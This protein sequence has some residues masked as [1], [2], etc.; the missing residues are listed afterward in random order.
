VFLRFGGVLHRGGVGVGCLLSEAV[1]LLLL[2]LEEE[3][4]VMHGNA[5]ELMDLVL[6]QEWDGRRRGLGDGVRRLG[7]SSGLGLGLGL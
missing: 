1:H 4:L 6:R 5:G 3:V 7:C 2:L